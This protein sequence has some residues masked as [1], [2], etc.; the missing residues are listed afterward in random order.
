MNVRRSKAFAERLPRSVQLQDGRCLEGARRVVRTG[1][2][3]CGA[4]DAVL[5]AIFAML[6]MKVPEASREV[7]AAPRPAL[8]LTE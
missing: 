8:S 6:E 2:E 5:F 7:P 1:C 3:L 4:C